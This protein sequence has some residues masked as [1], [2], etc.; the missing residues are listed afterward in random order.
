M[1]SVF[2]FLSVERTFWLYGKGFSPSPNEIYDVLENT[3]R[4]ADSSVRL[5]FIPSR[6]GP[7]GK[8]IGQRGTKQNL[9]S[10]NRFNSSIVMHIAWADCLHIHYK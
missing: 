6:S 5:L 9:Q 2:F 4:M 10:K 3:P 8:R 1:A 7:I